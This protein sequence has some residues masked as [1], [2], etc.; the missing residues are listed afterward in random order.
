VVG[1]VA[2]VD[3]LTQQNELVGIL[4]DQQDTKAAITDRIPNVVLG[5]N[6]Y[7]LVFEHHFNGFEGG[8]GWAV[9]EDK[10]VLY[11]ELWITGNFYHF[12]QEGAEDWRRHENVGATSVEDSV[13]GSLN[14]ETIF[15]A[16]EGW[17]LPNCGPEIILKERN[18]DHWAKW[19]TLDA[20]SKGWTK[21]DTGHIIVQTIHSEW[22]FRFLNDTLF[23]QGIHVEWTNLNQFVCQDHLVCLRKA[24]DAFDRLRQ[25]CLM[26]EREVFKISGTCRLITVEAYHIRVSLTFQGCRPIN[27]LWLLG[28]DW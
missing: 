3:R 2:L 21:V 19:S 12:H 24:Q 14:K 16:V 25:T 26:T 22:E 5:L 7:P 15:G 10:T 28:I 13:G 17:S 20:G 6:V 18:V 8:W 27:F 1:V 23:C 4:H 11:Y 9:N